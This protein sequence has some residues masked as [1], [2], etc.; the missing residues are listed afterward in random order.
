MKFVFTSIEKYLLQKVFK[1]LHLVVL[2]KTKKLHHWKKSIV[3]W[4]L[5]N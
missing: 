1:K 3:L 4:V 2:N 5:M